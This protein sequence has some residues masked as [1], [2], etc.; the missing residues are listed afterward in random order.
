MS[1]EVLWL[2]AVLLFLS[3]FGT[4][5]LEVVKEINGLSYPE[6]F[7]YDEESDCYFISNLGPKGGADGKDNDGFIT[8]LSGDF[9]KR[10]DK[11]VSGGLGIVLNAPKGLAVYEG[12][13]YVSDIDRLK[14]FNIKSGKQMVD[15]DLSILGAGFLN[16]VTVDD[17]G[18]VYITCTG[19]GMIFKYSTLTKKTDIW[20]KKGKIASRYFRYKTSK[21]CRRLYES[22][23]CGL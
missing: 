13:L 1:K 6:S 8:K 14:G 15:L 20:M 9:S 11:W 21:N 12:I 2:F 4:A 23:W 3:M 19:S 22:R 18:N 17:S 5:E 7:I 16:D 10:I